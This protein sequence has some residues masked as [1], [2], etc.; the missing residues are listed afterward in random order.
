[1]LYINEANFPDKAFREYI[2]NT[3]DVDKKSF[4]TAEEIKNVKELDLLFKKEIQSLK[5]IEYFQ[6]LEELY[7]VSTGITELNVRYNT[8]L[9][10]LICKDTAIKKLDITNNPELRVLNCAYTNLTNLDLSKNPKLEKLDYSFTSIII[11]DIRNNPNL[12][13]S[14]NR[15]KVGQAQEN[16]NEKQKV[17]KE[18]KAK[19]MER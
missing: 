10:I 3:F 6:N 11:L 18:V 9:E 17:K 19:E 7:C 12:R 13:V 15:G 8:K 2:S 1:M 14:S 5:G 16:L 4:L